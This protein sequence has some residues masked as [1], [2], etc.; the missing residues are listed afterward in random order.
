MIR[1]AGG[2]EWAIR[3]DN[4]AYKR[5]RWD[6]DAE[7]IGPK[8]H[9]ATWPSR[10]RAERAMRCVRYRQGWTPTVVPAD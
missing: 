9:R 1:P 8:K 10:E 7:G 4:P 2:Q 6:C 3:L 5:P